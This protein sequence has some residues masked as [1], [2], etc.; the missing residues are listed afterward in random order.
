MWTGSSHW[1]GGGGG[2]KPQTVIIYLY[3]YIY[4]CI[5]IYSYVDSTSYFL[6]SIGGIR[7]FQFNEMEIPS[8]NNQGFMGMDL[9]PPGPN[10]RSDVQSL[11]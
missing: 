4:I 3:L 9:F 7:I 11:E 6:F 8:F 5:D 2:R 1:G 10:L